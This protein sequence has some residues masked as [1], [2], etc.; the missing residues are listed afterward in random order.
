MGVT[1]TEPTDVHVNEMTERLN[2]GGRAAE[3]G[4]SGSGRSGAAAHG[5]RRRDGRGAQRTCAPRGARRP[6]ELG[7]WV[8]KGE[9]SH[10]NVNE[11][12]ERLNAGR[13]RAREEWKKR[14]PTTPTQT[15]GSVYQISS[16][17]DY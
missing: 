6:D 5:A 7:Q 11:I 16:S 10:L 1:A 14:Q 8:T 9:P 2:A 3:S 4:P 12:T 13:R 15:Q 17:G